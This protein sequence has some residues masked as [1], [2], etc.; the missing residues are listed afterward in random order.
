MFPTTGH[1]IN[2]IFGT[3]IEFPIPTYGLMLSSAFL[4]A[5]L[6][7][8]SEMKRKYKSGLLNPVKTEI[9]RGAA[10]TFSYLISPAIFGF[11]LGF[12]FLGIFFNYSAFNYDPAG[13]FFSFQGSW[14]VGFFVSACFTGWE[15]YQM[16]KKQ[17]PEPIKESIEQSPHRLM[18]VIL[19]IAA[20][21]GIV[22]AKLFH[23][24][25][26]LSEFYEDPLKTLFSAGGLTF[27]G[28]L[29]AGGLM[30]VWY[31]KY[32]KLNLLHMMDVTA[33][34]ILIAYAVGR[35]GCMLSGDGCWGIEN[36][37]PKPEWLNF[38]PDWMWA[39]NFP[40]NVVNEGI[41]LHD[42]YGKYCHILENPVYPTS[43]Y[44]TSLNL[45]FFVILWGLRNHIKIPGVLLA[46]VL[47][48]NGTARFFIEKIR[49]NNKLDFYGFTVTQAE[50]ISVLLVITGIILLI[51]LHSIHKKHNTD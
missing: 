5:W 47:I 23:I 37:N 18:P 27:Y 32:K 46:M 40:H 3:N 9:I 36:L 14:L 51:L 17:L 13:Y 34:A 39:F 6:V 21:S 10:P 31:C 12:K 26:N 35:T 50:I 19:I 1:L 16:K 22:G 2:A 44:E 4:F 33:P 30:V 11:I 49:I 48:M 24:L 43:F 28:G 45:I 38:L 20:S 41:V 7:A 15:Y 42:C 29:I 8:G 25:E